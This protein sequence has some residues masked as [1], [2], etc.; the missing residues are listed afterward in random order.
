MALI[1]LAVGINAKL[2]TF[3]KEH[4]VISQEMRCWSI[5]FGHNSSASSW[6]EKSKNVAM[7]P[8]YKKYFIMKIEC[9][10][11]AC[12][13]LTVTFAAVALI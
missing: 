1:W 13:K 10:H 6:A 8:T 9:M 5:L 12:W 7:T 3:Y 2:K 4:F 11:K